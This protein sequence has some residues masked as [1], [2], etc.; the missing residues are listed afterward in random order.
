MDTVF[1]VATLKMQMA[2]PVP[3]ELG[4]WMRAWGE[5]A[6]CNMCGEAQ[7][8]DAVAA[9]GVQVRWMQWPRRGFR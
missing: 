3:M 2:K 8:V 6:V 7:E 9:S 1:S 4:S 5:A